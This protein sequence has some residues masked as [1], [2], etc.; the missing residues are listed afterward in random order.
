MFKRLG[1]STV[2]SA[3]GSI[4]GITDRYTIEYRENDEMAKIAVDL[5][6]PTF[7]VYRDTLTG[8]ILADVTTLPMTDT[9]RLQVLDYIGRGL[10]CMDVK[11]EWVYGPSP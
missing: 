5:G 11:V 10:A 9:D 1:P 8:W 7:G 3:S 2:Q 6:I 4:I